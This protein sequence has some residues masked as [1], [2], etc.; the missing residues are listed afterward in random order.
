MKL[1]QENQGNICFVVDGRIILEQILEKYSKLRDVNQI[2]VKQVM[3]QEQHDNQY[4]E[5]CTMNFAQ[6]IIQTIKF[7]IYIY[8]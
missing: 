8:I 4:F 5:V 6:I 7:T 2:D 3:V 1:W